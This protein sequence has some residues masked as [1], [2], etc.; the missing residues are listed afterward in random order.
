MNSNY[1]IDETKDNKKILTITCTPQDLYSCFSAFCNENP[2]LILTKIIK[3]DISH[4]STDDTYACS[5]ELGDD[6]DKKH[7]Q[8]LF[9][10][11]CR[12]SENPEQTFN[13]LIKTHITDKCIRKKRYYSYIPH[14]MQHRKI[15]ESKNSMNNYLVLSDIIE[16]EKEFE[17]VTVPPSEAINIYLKDHPDLRLIGLCNGD[18][19][20]REAPSWASKSGTYQKHYSVTALFASIKDFPELARIKS[21]GVLTL[22]NHPSSSVESQT[23]S[24]LKKRNDR[25]GMNNTTSEFVVALK[26]PI[27]ETFLDQENDNGNVTITLQDGSSRTIAGYCNQYYIVINE[28]ERQ[29]A[30]PII[31]KPETND[32]TNDRLVPC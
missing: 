32:R 6:P 3:A 5:F 25:A 2:G 11:S 20:R 23:E 27:G 12:T 14:Q 19:E 4:G 7:H 31:K 1:T 30:S 21:Q 26:Y 10:G 24:L 13:N 22:L 15:K 17:G 18:E 8:H 29:I 28:Q 16:T 9:R